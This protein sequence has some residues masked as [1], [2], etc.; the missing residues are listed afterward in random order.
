MS[1]S[2]HLLYVSILTCT[3]IIPVTGPLKI[4]FGCYFGFPPRIVIDTLEF[5]IRLLGWKVGN[6]PDD[7][8]DPDDGTT[9][10][11]EE[12]NSTAEESTSSCTTSV[13]ATYESVFCSVTG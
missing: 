2:D 1:N 11:N 9:K 12:P 3:V 5:C 10:S 4:Y 6:C 8:P 7:E 13:V